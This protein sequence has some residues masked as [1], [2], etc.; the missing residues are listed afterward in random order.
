MEAWLGKTV[1]VVDRNGGGIIETKT[2]ESGIHFFGR[3]IRHKS[4]SGTLVFTSRLSEEKKM[5][6]LT[7]SYIQN[8]YAENPLPIDLFPVDSRFIVVDKTEKNY[9]MDWQ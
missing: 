5:K 3:E 4:V 1:V 7:V 9:V 6:E 8:P 2:D